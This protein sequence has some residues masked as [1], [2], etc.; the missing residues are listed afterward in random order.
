[1]NDTLLH[2]TVLVGAWL[3]TVLCVIV[4]YE[5]LRFLG[6]TLGAHVHRRI[7]MLLVMLGLLIA[8]MI[9][10]WIFALGY[11]IAAVT[12][13]GTFGHLIGIENPGIFDYMYLSSMVYTTVGFGDV[14]PVGAVRMLAAAEALTGLAL[15][16]WSASY[17][18]LAMQRFWP[19]PLSGRD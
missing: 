8:H 15:I 18:F 17:T 19:A 13:V 9:E 3:I 5:A 10:I 16:T 1:M 6:R 14:V 4:H 12:T 11:R 7:G 2:A